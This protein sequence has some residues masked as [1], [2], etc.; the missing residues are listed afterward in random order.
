MPDAI[1]RWRPARPPARASK[2]TAHYRTSDW[3][4]LRL[5]VLVRDAYRCAA[6]LRCVAGRHAH[7]DHIVPLEQGGTD[8]LENL[9]VLCDED[10][11]RKTRDEQR[12]AGHLPG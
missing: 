7:V 2:Q 12:R 8:R 4:A 11:G 1:Q 3:A 9:Q 6:C 5:E 10:H